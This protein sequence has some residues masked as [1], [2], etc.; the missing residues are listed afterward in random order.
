MTNLDKPIVPPY[1]KRFYSESD[2]ENRIDIL[3]NMPDAFI[4]IGHDGEF[5][6]VNR[7]AETCFGPR[8]KLL[9][10]NMWEEFKGVISE[11]FR[12][13]YLHSMQFLTPVDFEEQFECW[14]AWYQCYGFPTADGFYWFFRNITDKKNIEKK[15]NCL[16]ESS[17]I[18]ITLGSDNGFITGANQTFLTMI[19]Y[20]AEDLAN[21]KVSWKQI[22]P[23]EYSEVSEK[24][25]REAVERGQ[26][27]IYEKEYITKSGKRVPVL[28]GLT[29]S[30]KRE[31]EI[32]G[33]TLDISVQKQAQAQ[34][35][36][37]IEFK[38]AL[39]VRDEFSAVAAHELRSPLT[40]LKLKL[41]LIKMLFTESEIPEFKF[42]STI[43]RNLDGCTALISRFEK[44]ITELFD[45]N[46]IRLGILD[47]DL[48]IFDI[49]NLISDV[50]P[51]FKEGLYASSDYLKFNKTNPI[52]GKW[53]FMRLE[54]AISNLISNAIKYGNQ[55]PIEINLSN[56]QDGSGIMIRVQD[57]GYGIPVQ[58]Q[59]KI[60]Q[61]FHR[62]ENAAQ[63]AE[64][65]GVG[66]F[67]TK[68][69]IEIHGGKISVESIPNI[70]SV[71][72][73]FLPLKR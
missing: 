36:S 12:K 5:T 70:G 45:F 51:R 38:E 43:R 50:L 60:F 23:P 67:I 10:K 19:E 28:V 53:D 42:L 49:N 61:L 26:A 65:L 55:K 29:L 66:L 11:K 69:I 4:A 73:L 62:A 15:M 59:S 48:E 24:A 54:Q 2:A 18:G 37:I 47:L 33:F 31:R 35:E 32:M 72:N 9:G 64:G 17:L 34:R 20:N 68:Q 25:I 3:E 57:H 56:S 39:R 21:G 14:K 58:D 40:A 63:R 46:K 13:T 6:Y 30:D 27:E 41:G 8:E 71:F 52:F 7:V 22:T 44:L 1:Y 16:F